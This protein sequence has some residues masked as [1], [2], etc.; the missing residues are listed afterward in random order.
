[1]LCSLQLPLP[2]LPEGGL[3]A[4]EALRAGT[5]RPLMLWVVGPERMRGGRLGDTERGDHLRACLQD[6]FDLDLTYLTDRIVVMGFPATGLGKASSTTYIYT[7]HSVE[8][9]VAPFPHEVEAD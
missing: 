2:L 8:A 4:Q 9:E 6:G 7:G 5:T 3:S 1:M